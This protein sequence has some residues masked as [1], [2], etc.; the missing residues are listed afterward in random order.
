MDP[1]LVT[2]HKLVARTVLVGSLAAVIGLGGW[3][4]TQRATNHWAEVER[5]RFHLD[6]GEPDLAFAAVSGIRD[7]APGAAEGLS[8]AAT[9]LVRQGNVPLAADGAWSG[10]S[11]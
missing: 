7:D 4:W 5:A 6:R 1:A 3:A 10:A 9:A 8:L 2:R 11:R